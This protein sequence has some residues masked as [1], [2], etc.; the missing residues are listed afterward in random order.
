M[1]GSSRKH[2]TV[3]ELVE[4]Y[5]S[6]SVEEARGLLQAIAQAKAMSATGTQFLTKIGNEVVIAEP[7]EELRIEARTRLV[8]H[9]VSR[10]KLPNEFEIATL[11]VGF[12]AQSRVHTVCATRDEK[13]LHEFLR[14]YCYKVAHPVRGLIDPVLAAALVHTRQFEFLVQVQA[15]GAIP[16]IYNRLLNGQWT[17]RFDQATYALD[18]SSADYERILK[19]T[20][21]LLASIEDGFCKPASKA[22]LALLAL[23]CHQSG[24]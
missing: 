6:A 17:A 21:F 23:Q 4:R 13:L 18:G 8:R 14:E 15:F 11:C 24:L 22:V 2:A 9:L 16:L 12:F 7:D 10:I 3:E 19:V 5:S 20:G 1:Q